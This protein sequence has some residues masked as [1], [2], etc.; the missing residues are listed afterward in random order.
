MQS[1]ELDHKDQDFCAGP[2]SNDAAEPPSGIAGYRAFKPRSGGRYSEMHFPRGER[3]PVV[4]RN[5]RVCASCN[6]RYLEAWEE[7][8][9]MTLE[10]DAEIVLAKFKR[11]T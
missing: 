5:V 7:G 10:L 8:D 3:P 6:N 2:C 1:L 4:V 9:W 11:L